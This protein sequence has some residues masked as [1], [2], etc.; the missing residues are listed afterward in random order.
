MINVFNGVDSE[1]INPMKK[2]LIFQHIPKTAGSTLLTLLTKRYPKDRIFQCGSDGVLQDFINLDGTLREGIELL[3]GHVDYGIHNYFSSSS[4]Y[5]TFLRDPIVRTLS[6]YNFIKRTK[7]HRFHEEAKKMGLGDFVR[8]GIRPRMNNCIVRML[9]G[10][11]PVYG[12]LSENLV[13]AAFENLHKHYCFVGFVDDF[14]RSVYRL[15]DLFGWEKPV[16]NVVNTAPNKTNP[17]DMNLKDL[18]ILLE[19]N[20]LDIIFYDRISNDRQFLGYKEKVK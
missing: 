9:S 12:S 5:F 10:I 1:I 6:H 16:Y 7:Q 3:A 14:E 2:R 18:D 20:S 19:Y 8:S 13:D 11:N 17:F 4:V 15:S